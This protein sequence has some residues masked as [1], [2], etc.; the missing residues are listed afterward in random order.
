MLGHR[1]LTFEDYI[2]ILK[3]RLWMILL[4]A[5]IIPAL[6]V[7]ATFI[8]HPRFLSQTLVIIQQQKVPDDFVKPVLN[9]D[10]N[11]RLASMRE[12][13]FSR[14]RLQP[15][16]DRFGL[17]SKEP[18]LEARLDAMRKAIDLK[19]IRSQLTNTN[20][21]PG[22][23]ISFTTDN[24]RT[25][26]Q[27]CGEITSMFLSEN[28]RAREQSAQGTTDFLK[29]QLEDAKRSLDEQDAKLAEF[30]RKYLGELPEQETSNAN[31]LTS[32]NTQ[33]DAATQNLSRMEQDKTYLE[34][35]LAQQTGAVEANAGERPDKGG[36]TPALRPQAVV[37]PE[38][39]KMEAQAAA[40]EARYTPDHPDVLKMHREI[41]AKKKT[42]A[43]AATQNQSGEP[44]KVGQ[45]APQTNRP[46][47]QKLQAQITGLSGGIVTKKA[48]QTRIQQQMNMYQSRIQSS[49][50]VQ[51]QYK[52]ITR[53]YQTALQFYNEL[54]AKRNRSEMAM[55][56]EHRQEGE[57]FLVMD[58]PNLPEQPIFPNR[59]LFGIAGLA[60]GLIFGVMLA[61]YFE[62][63]DEGFRN[64]RDV[65][66]L[67]KLSTLVSIP[68]VASDEKQGSRLA[69]WVGRGNRA[70]E[71]Q[72]MSVG[73]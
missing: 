1:E 46:E 67:T 30:Q 61:A 47:L 71:K 36:T 70:K 5:T 40:L 58:P 66:A 65:L 73:G 68:W 39:Q 42:L 17:Y 35:L 43:A 24:A 69:R 72:P 33:L 54:L 60:V 49:P 9:E 64:D 7:G 15:I 27:V 51:E 29:G 23:F 45:S 50:A 20:G 55:D 31:M 3:R 8:I 63:R 13:I 34:A 57:Q 38:L 14:T 22:F 18:T 12:Q 2:A 62:Y 53:D 41:E 59:D 44:K 48:D 25:A 6:A 37:D 19:P 56:L 16:I 11:A 10:L 21:L 32:L 26:Q 28:L 52:Q 4:P